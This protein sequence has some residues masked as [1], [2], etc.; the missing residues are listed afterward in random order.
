MSRHAAAPLTKVTMNFYTTD[1]KFMQ[2]HFGQGWSEI[3]REQIHRYVE[4]VKKGPADE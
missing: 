2:D 1:V 3:I 4:R